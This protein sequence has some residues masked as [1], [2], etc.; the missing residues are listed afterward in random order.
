MPQSDLFCASSQ[1]ASF[2]DG[3]ECSPLPFSKRKYL[4]AQLRQK[5]AFIDSLLAKLR[6]KDEFIDSLLKKQV[7]LSDVLKA[8]AAYTG[9]YRNPVNLLTNP[10]QHDTRASKGGGQTDES[11]KEHTWQKHAQ[12][13]STSSSSGNTPLFPNTSVGLDV[14]TYPK[15][16]ALD[17]GATVPNESMERR[18]SD[19]LGN[20]NF[21]MSPDPDFTFGAMGQH[22]DLMDFTFDPISP[23]NEETLMQAL[24]SPVFLGD[25]L[26]PGLVDG[27][28]HVVPVRLLTC[29]QILLACGI[30]DSGT[31][32]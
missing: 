25:T 8:N 21:Y 29:A 26:I 19:H 27:P 1:S 30:V 5:D 18:N 3:D 13:L 28:L 12:A 16:A 32:G 14:D 6:E 10:F 20:F 24:R 9:A 31:V 15:D 4:L 17:G 11:D 22:N 2:P 7:C 23:S